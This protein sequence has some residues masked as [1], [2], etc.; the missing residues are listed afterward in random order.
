MAEEKKSIEISYKANL[1]DLVSKLKTLPNVTGQ[2]AK[3]MVAELDRQL[4]QAERAAKKSADAQKKAAAAARKAFQQNRSAISGIN[5]AAKETEEKLEGVADSAG[6]V[7][8]G[9]A[10]IGLALSAVNPQLGEAAML[11]ADVAAVSEGLLL[12]FKNLNPIVL[13]LSAA[14]ATLTLGYAAYSQEMEIARQ[15]TIAIRIADEE[16]AKALEE[17]RE[18][19]RDA[20][21]SFR[22]ISEELLVLQGRLS[23][24]TFEMR[25]LTRA[26]RAQ[27]STQEIDQRIE[28]L[29]EE[30][31]L[32]RRAANDMNSL[33]DEEK[34]R[35]T[36]I[37]EATAGLEKQNI[38]FEDG[39]IRTNNL[40]K[41]L[42]RVTGQIQD[43]REIRNDVLDQEREAVAAALEIKKIKDKQ[44]EEEAEE[45]RKKR[46]ARAAEEKRQK[47]EQERLD[48][49][50]EARKQENETLKQKEELQKMFTRLSE[51]DNEKL[52]RQ[53]NERADLE[54]EKAKELAL[55]TDEFELAEKVI[56]QAELKRLAEIQDLQTRIA[57]ERMKSIKQI[58]SQGLNDLSMFSQ[59]GIDRIE[60]NYSKSEE[61]INKQFDL[62]AEHL[63]KTY[64]ALEDK[65]LLNK[66]LHQNEMD[67]EKSL[68][69]A[70]TIYINGNKIDAE[71]AALGLFRLQQAASIAN[72]AMTTA[73][74]INKYYGS[75]PLAPF[76][77][78]GAIAS[79]TAQTAA[80]LSQQP[81]SLHM[82]GLAPDEQT[83]ILTGEAVLD[84]ATTR[85]LG[86]EGVR[87][88]QN[89][90]MGTDQIVIIQP[91]RHIDRYNR[92]AA[93]RI[94]RAVGSAGY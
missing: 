31:K 94:P 8:R 48:E 36:A 20:E 65:E 51:T 89:D 53:I 67:R 82:G 68:A 77:I 5:D 73:E 52:I 21:R 55:L 69:K 72:I 85:R 19:V 6:E 30:E 54:I 88:L 91:F 29:Q 76:L 81:P 39:T 43:Q 23:Q 25:Q 80:V 56:H 14:V 49:I 78:A 13:G 35:L 2:E 7:D 46:A 70:R 1:K 34:D 64:S 61:L 11:G 45:V 18:A 28:A 38:L 17:S 37:L 10:S 3:K 79:G 75:G 32:L 27:F 84:R 63:E 58:A 71:E 59:A 33:S 93:R 57:D 15:K 12:T 74:N 50:I 42:E 22:D 92:S 4:K 47:E 83:T 60:Q 87:R 9:F 40:K 90:T 62:E 26:T 41:A 86:D 24:S 44:R 16:H 66:K